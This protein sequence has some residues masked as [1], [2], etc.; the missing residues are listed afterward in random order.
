M[1]VL[2]FAEATRFNLSP[3]GNSQRCRASELRAQRLP[4]SFLPSSFSSFRI[5]NSS[6]R[7]PVFRAATTHLGCFPLPDHV[8]DGLN[9]LQ[10]LG[11]TFGY[12]RRGARL[13]DGLL[14]RADGLIC[15]TR[16]S[17]ANRF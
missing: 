11:R 9:G 13:T 4:T 8:S 10:Y 1:L 16:F 6:S 12:L 2:T 14:A 17:W 15:S 3:L 7:C 5:L